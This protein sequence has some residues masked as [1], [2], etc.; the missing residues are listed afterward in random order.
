MKKLRLDEL[1]VEQGLADSIDMAKRLIMAGEI[2]TGGALRL[3][4]LLPAKR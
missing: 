2:R 1:V 4:P 3:D